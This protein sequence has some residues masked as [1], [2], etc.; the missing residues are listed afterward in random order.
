[1]ESE[2]LVRNTLQRSDG[3]SEVMNLR[4]REDAETC[5]RFLE[6]KKPGG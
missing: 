4:K 2:K 1:M 6:Q 5:F 3:I